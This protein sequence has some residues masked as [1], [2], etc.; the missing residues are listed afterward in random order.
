MAAETLNFGPE[1]LRALS[2]GGSVASPPPSPAMPKYKLAEYRYGREE[3]LALYIKENKVPEEMQDKEFA[4]ILNEEPLQPLALLPLT[5][6]EQR[7]FSMS[8]NSVPVL[9]LMGKSAAPPT[10]GAAPRGRGTARGRGR[11]RGDAAVFPRPADEAEPGFGRGREIH[12][13]QS[14]DDRIPPAAHPDQRC[15]IMSESGP[16]VRYSEPGGTCGIKSEAAPAI[17]GDRRFEKPVRREAV[18]V[19]FEEA[20][21]ARKEFARSDS[22]NWRTLRDGQEEDEDGNWRLAV[23]RRDERWRSTSPG[24]TEGPRSAGWREPGERRRKFDF[25]VVPE[26][27]RGS[28]QRGRGSDGAHGDDRDGLPEWCM[29]DEDD[30]MGTFDS[31]GAFLSFKKSPKET[32]VE[33]QELEFLGVEEDYEEEKGDNSTGDKL[34]GED[35]LALSE[36]ILLEPSSTSPDSAN[37]MWASGMFGEM[38]SERC[39]E[40]SSSTPEADGAISSEQTPLPADDGGDP[41]PFIPSPLSS[42]PPPSSSP[43][44]A[45]TEFSVGDPEEDEGMK[46][47]QQEAEKLVAS[48]QDSSLEEDGFSSRSHSAAALPLGHEA[49][50]KWFYK[51]PQG[52]IQGPFSTQEMAEWCQAGYFTMSLLVKRGCD[53]GF[54]PL[55]EVIKMWGRVPFAPGPSPPPLLHNH[56]KGFRLPQGNIDQQCLKKQQELALYQQLQHQYILQV[57]GRQSSYS[58]QKSGDLTPQQQQQL[59]LFLQQ[60]NPSKS[61]GSDASLLP[62]MNRSLSVPDTGSLW[63]LNTSN[64][65]TAGADSN[66]WD[67]PVTS[68]SQG[69]ILEQLQLQQKLQERRDAELRAKREEDDRKRRDEKRRQEEQKRRDQEEEMYRR[70]QL[71][72]EQRLGDKLH[73]LSLSRQQQELLLKLIQQS[74]QQSQSQ[75][76]AA[77]SKGLSLKAMLEMQEREGQLLKQRGQTSR[78]VHGGLG[79]SSSSSIIPSQWGSDSGSLWGGLEKS[80][81]EES[82]KSGASARGLRN[83][84]SSPSLTDAYAASAARRKKTEEEEKLL[85]LLQGIKPSDGFTQWCEQMLHMINTSNNLD[86][87]TL[88]AFLKE[89]ESPYDVHDYIRSCLGE[90]LEAKEFAKQFLERRAKYKASQRQQ[91]EAAWMAPT[92]FP[93]TQNSKPGSG[94]D[95]QSSKMKR[96]IQMLHSDPSI[97]GYS[98]HGSPNEMEAIDDY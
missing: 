98:L 24:G 90:T 3:M 65:S 92:M 77:H 64:T 82:V 23:S 32:I 15:G 19:G 36:E 8:V 39:P 66:L 6:D 41:G 54:Q 85:K 71:Q 60:L 87:P 97:L 34:N 25:D 50:M 72:I 26:E 67:L 76:W 57:L 84:R 18:R 20:A 27:G 14:W 9:R 96:R 48:L 80:P 38:E 74:G 63:D 94:Y 55:G 40:M 45:A 56:P 53:E 49:A 17:R 5:E 75:V 59:T 61:R 52:E 46:H 16:A 83:S 86:V 21:A 13:S 1:W 79:M 91:Q 51:D 47:L 93:A 42:L 43:P 78:N 2:S 95:V 88:V 62:S 28:G 11:G 70:K 37:S 69:P 10:A 33:E 7:N 22:D 44:H 4:V 68:V 31:S 81:W 12:R 29:E 58:Q 35:S 89:L 73:M 30:E